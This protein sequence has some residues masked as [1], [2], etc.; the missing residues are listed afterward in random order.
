VSAFLKHHADTMWTTYE[1]LRI[2]LFGYFQHKIMSLSARDVQ[3]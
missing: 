3:L 2:Y 1:L